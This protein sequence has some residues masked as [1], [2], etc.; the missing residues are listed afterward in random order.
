MFAHKTLSYEEA[1]GEGEVGFE[2]LN[3]KQKNAF[4]CLRN[5]FC[6]IK[7]E[8][9]DLYTA[10][11][12]Y[13]ENGLADEKYEQLLDNFSSV[14]KQIDIFWKLFKEILDEDKHI[15]VNF[16]YYIEGCFFALSEISFAGMKIIKPLIEDKKAGKV[17][18]YDIDRKKILNSVC[19]IIDYARDI[20]VYFKIDTTEMV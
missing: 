15:L 6:N 10:Y 17:V 18:N 11:V 7:N 13:L 19:E 20:A 1:K 9:I 12:V 5:S 8:F 3:T 14:E 16:I 2:D 4:F